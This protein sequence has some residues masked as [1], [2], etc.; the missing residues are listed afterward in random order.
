ML[1]DIAED[2]KK[3]TILTMPL[4]KEDFY[5]FLLKS[6]QPELSHI[7]ISLVEGKIYEA[8]T[9]GSTDAEKSDHNVPSNSRKGKSRFN[10][11]KFSTARKGF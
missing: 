7:K 8:K 11:G 2:E 5:S 4:V 6:V 1:I 3:F 10:K 9:T